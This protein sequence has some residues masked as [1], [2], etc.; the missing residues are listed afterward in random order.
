MCWLAGKIWLWRLH[1]AYGADE[2]KAVAKIYYKDSHP[3]QKYWIT[4]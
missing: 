1:K 2:M 3:F 4:E